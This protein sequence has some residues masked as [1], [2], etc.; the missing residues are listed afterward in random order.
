VRKALDRVR[1]LSFGGSAQSGQDVRVSAARA[2]IPEPALLFTFLGR[3]S[4]RAGR[5]YERILAALVPK[6]GKAQAF[7]HTGQWLTLAD[8]QKGIPTRGVWE[9]HFASWADGSQSAATSEALE[10]FRPLA[11]AFAQERKQAL[12]QER[13]SHGSWITE[14]VREITDGTLPPDAQLHLF[15]GSR[16]TLE[17]GKPSPDWSRITDPVER[18]AAFALDRTQMPSKLS[19]ADSALRIY[20]QRLEELEKHLALEEPEIVPLGML[21]LLPQ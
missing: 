9:K 12:E 4:S 10:A 14:R 21:M 8:P 19:E 1:N 2:E 15:P 13:T 7:E 16:P 18:L 11:H 17:T 6:S 5:E 20:R 3:A